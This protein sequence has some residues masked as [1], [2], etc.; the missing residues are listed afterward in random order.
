MTNGADKGLLANKKN[1]SAIITR[2][3]NQLVIICT[4]NNNH[5][6]EI[7]WRRE[8]ATIAL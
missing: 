8:A 1:E 5:G 3:K 7:S 6:K 4:Y 2:A